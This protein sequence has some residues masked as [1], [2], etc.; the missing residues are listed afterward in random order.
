VTETIPAGWYQS[1]PGT[2]AS[3]AGYS[4]NLTS[5]QTDSD[6][7]FGNFQKATKSGYKFNDLNANGVWD[8]G[9]PGLEDWTITLSGTDGL[10]NSVN[11]TAQT[12]VNGAYSFMVNPGTYDVT[13]TIL[14]D[15]YQS[16]PGT[17]LSPAGYSINLT[18]GQ[19]DSDND[20][21]NFHKATKSGHKFNDLNANG[22]WD[23][24][25]PAAANWTITLTGTDGLGNSVNL[26]T[27][28][29]VNGAY[30]FM[31]NPGSYTVNETIL[32]DWYQSKP[33]TPESPAGYSINLTSGQTDSDNDFGNFQQADLRVAKSGTI[34]YS[35]NV[36]ND[37]PSTA[38]NVVVS[39]NLTP[40]L[41]WSLKSVSG[42]PEGSTFNITDGHL[43]QGFVPELASGATIE[44]TVEATIDGDSP[45]PL[46]GNIAEAFSDTPD[47]NMDNNLDDADIGP[48]S[49]G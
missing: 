30:S 48:P 3:P 43:L 44:I 20:F 28:T 8:Q 34:S 10:G 25:E 9:E 5:G 45:D 40:Y 31:V 14:A 19:T 17:P 16:N 1:K 37:G 35:V 7:D 23:Q 13:E 22:D 33:G 26:S 6:N 18:S 29:D 12:D 27:Q 47:P 32:A 46:L 15:W 36:T 41:T 24:G 4:I 11:M 38:L 21:G 49:P 2:P 39:D 42:A